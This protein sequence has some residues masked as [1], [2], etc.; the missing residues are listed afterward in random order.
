M[1][2]M[3]LEH[4]LKFGFFGFSQTELI[5]TMMAMMMMTMHVQHSNMTCLCVYVCV[6]VILEQESDEF[7]FVIW[8]PNCGIALVRMNHI[9]QQRNE[10]K[11]N[12]IR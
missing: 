2:C 10:L 8:R 5:M 7:M 9:S 3:R 12:C 4:N 11:I 6:Y 1:M